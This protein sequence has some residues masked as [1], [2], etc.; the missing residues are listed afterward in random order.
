MSISASITTAAFTAFFGVLVLVAGQLIQRF[1]IEPIHDQ[2]KAI[3]EAA[4]NYTFLA[5]LNY[6][7]RFQGVPL[8][9]P[10]EPQEAS[11][12]LR[13]IAGQLRAS[14]VTV[15][16]YDRLA[17]NGFVLSRADV[18]KLST[19]LIGLSNSLWEGD[20]K[21]ARTMIAEVLRLDAQFE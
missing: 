12:T 10:A 8:Q 13:R 17:A 14:L 9:Y 18:M 21:H 19:G 7:G 4:F 1:V 11:R 3:G 16:C 6:V 2:K 20:Q 5:N 15:P